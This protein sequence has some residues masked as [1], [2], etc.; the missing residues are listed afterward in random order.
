MYSYSPRPFQL[1]AAVVG[2]RL[3]RGKGSG[4]LERGREVPR[5]GY[6]G[7]GARIEM[8]SE[9]ARMGLDMEGLRSGMRMIIE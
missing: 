3:S 1:Q 9:D 2:G 6:L 8:R 7:N 5:F 4:T